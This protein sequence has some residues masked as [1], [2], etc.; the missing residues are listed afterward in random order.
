MPL[1]QMQKSLSFYRLLEI[2]VEDIIKM[3]HRFENFAKIIFLPLFIS[4]LQLLTRNEQKFAKFRMASLNGPADW[5]Q[6]K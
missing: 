3:M 4:E 1:Y 2:T 5:R 6:A